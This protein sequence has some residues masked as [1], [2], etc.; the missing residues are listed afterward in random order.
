MSTQWI[1]QTLIASVLTVLMTLPATAQ[2]RR[3]S[4]PTKAA[5]GT[6][7]KLEVPPKLQPAFRNA[8]EAQKVVIRAQIAA[9]KALEKLNL[10]V[11]GFVKAGGHKEEIA[12]S[13][14]VAARKA[15]NE[16]AARG[17]QK[18]DV[19]ISNPYA[20]QGGTPKKEKVSE[21]NPFAFQSSQQT[22]EAF[23]KLVTLI[24]PAVQNIYDTTGGKTMR[25]STT[26]G[27]K[28]SYR[29]GGGSGGRVNF[30]AQAVSKELDGAIGDLNTQLNLLAA[31]SKGK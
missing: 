14:L 11:D 25:M 28:S 21:A 19:T 20:L 22:E 8:I 3:L 7:G 18:E 1:K 10:E 27:S 26:H 2:Q 12:P 13:N 5:A 4:G 9:F 29:G 23:F 17:P 15:G 16:S 30:D 6:P 31:L 24:L